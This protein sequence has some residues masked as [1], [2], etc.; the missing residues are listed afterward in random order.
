MSWHGQFQPVLCDCDPQDSTYSGAKCLHHLKIP[1]S[2]SAICI[3]WLCAVSHLRYETIVSQ[4]FGVW[5][6][7][8]TPL[9]RLIYLSVCIG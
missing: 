4:F 5:T 6:Q 9:N 8:S 3:D 1:K 2:W 7:K